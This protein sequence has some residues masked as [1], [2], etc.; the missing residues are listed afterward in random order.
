MEYWEDKENMLCVTIYTDTTGQYTDEE[1]DRW[2]NLLDIPV[3][4]DLLWEWYKDCERFDREESCWVPD[5]GYTDS[6]YEDFRKWYEEEYT[7][8]DVNSLYSWLV[9]HGYHWKRLD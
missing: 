3:P 9:A 1:I 6:T 7:A 4:E 2:G 8:D 5:G